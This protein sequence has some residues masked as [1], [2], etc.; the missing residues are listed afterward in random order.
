MG[1]L[2]GSFGGRPI[3]EGFCVLDLHLCN[4]AHR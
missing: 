3:F 2:D 1:W 4:C